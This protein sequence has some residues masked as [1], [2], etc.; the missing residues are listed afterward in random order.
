MRMLRISEKKH[1]IALNSANKSSANYL[2]YFRM[3]V[4]DTMKSISVKE[5]IWIINDT[6]V[7]M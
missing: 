2:Q 4:R 3:K 5:V 7:E 1:W 6:E